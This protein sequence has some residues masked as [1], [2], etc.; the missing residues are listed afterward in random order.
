MFEPLASIRPEGVRAIIYR[1][2]MIG[3]EA[4]PPFATHAWQHARCSADA[5]ARAIGSTSSCLR[6]RRT[7]SRSPAHYHRITVVTRTV[8]RTCGY[9][10]DDCCGK[11]IFRDRDGL[12]VPSVRAGLEGLIAS[13]ATTV[14]QSA[15]FQRVCIPTLG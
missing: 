3:S 4:Q 11:V 12:S 1:P 14:S 8:D 2:S 9:R 5:L 13:D 6:G 10:H 7:R 15:A